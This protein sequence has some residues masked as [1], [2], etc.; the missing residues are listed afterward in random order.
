MIFRK[1][2]KYCGVGIALGL[3]ACATGQ[4]AQIGLAQMGKTLTV[5]ADGCDFTKIQAAID[6]AAAG[7]TIHVKAGT[8]QENVSIKEKQDLV[9][10]GA[11]RD[12]VTLDGSAG[13]SEQRPGIYIEKSKNVTVKGFQ[14]VQSRR[15]VQ[16]TETTGFV[17]TDS[18]LEGNFRQGLLLQQV[19]AKLANIIVQNTQTD[20]DGANGIAIQLIDSQV[21]L[22]DCVVS[23]NAERGLVL[24]GTNKPTL[25]MENCTISDNIGV[26]IHL[27]SLAEATI[28]STRVTG[29][30]ADAK[31]R[32][33]IGIVIQADSKATIEN[34]TVE[35]GAAFGVYVQDNGKATIRK[36]TVANNISI[37]VYLRH[38]ARATL[39]DNTVIRNGFSGVYVWDKA[40][41]TILNNRIM[42]TQRDVQGSNGVGIAIGA[43]SKAT[44]ENT[45]V[46]GSAA[47]GV[48]VR[49]NGQAIIRKSTIANN[50]SFGIYLVHNSKTKLEENT[51]AG[52]RTEGIAATNSAQATLVK[53]RIVEQ[54][55]RLEGGFG[56]GISAFRDAQ[57]TLQDNEIANNSSH[58]IDLY[59]R[60]QVTMTNNTISGNSGDG[61]ALSHSSFANE[62]I[63]VEAVSNGIQDNRGCG[64]RLRDTDSGITI[65]GQGNTIANNIQGQLCGDQSKIPTGFGGGK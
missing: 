56:R 16:A 38:N 24:Q 25:A 14:I 26:A 35:G 5:C 8:Y 63:R 36:S 28:L 44:V 33:G 42:E 18:R 6:A 15:A 45:T 23:G 65:T 40:E 49:D 20:R 58:G 60:V 50:T 53:N 61:I 10:Q 62:T 51:I 17:M 19:E 52:N 21:V 41:A 3:M 11:S 31:G 27:F 32:D 9:L 22:K 4:I 46:E 43:D 34:T 39:E 7:D 47:F 12:E 48:L 13:A 64:V 57:L 54:K 30:K 29:T 55:P 1:L 37:G 2:L 59:E